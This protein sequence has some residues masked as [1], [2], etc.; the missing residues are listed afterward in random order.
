MNQFITQQLN[1]IADSLEELDEVM[2]ATQE[3]LAGL[4]GARD[5]LRKESWSRAKE[6]EVLRERLED[7][8]QL[9]RENERLQAQNAEFE[10]RLRQ[11][12]RYTRA[13]G[14]EM[15]P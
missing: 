2:T 7:Y 6:L 12:L 15:R 3:Q 4:T 1:D 14:A 11:I 9:K 10:K 8:P 5:G 13:L